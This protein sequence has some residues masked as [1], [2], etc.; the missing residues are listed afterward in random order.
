MEE[1]II[2]KQYEAVRRSGITNMADRGRV[3][4]HAYHAGFHE[5]VTWI[6]EVESGEEYLQ[7]ANEF[8]E[9]WREEDISPFQVSHVRNGN[10]EGEKVKRGRSPD[11]EDVLDENSTADEL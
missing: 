10:F 9:E 5:L 3:Q 8:A 2:A 11:P 6:E 7:N 4:Y 1:D